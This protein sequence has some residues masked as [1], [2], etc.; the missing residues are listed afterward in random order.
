MMPGRDSWPGSKKP[1]KN[2]KKTKK[3]PT[4]NWIILSAYQY[5]VP[6]VLDYAITG[7]WFLVPVS[8]FLFPVSCFLFGSIV[9]SILFCSKEGGLVQKK[10]DQPPN[11]LFPLFLFPSDPASAHFRNEICVFPFLSYFRA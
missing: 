8:C 11:I 5:E 1:Q 6:S 10:L 3:K 2:Q 9:G 7:S 4:F